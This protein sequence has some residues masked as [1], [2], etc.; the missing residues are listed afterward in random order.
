MWTWHAIQLHWIDH[1]MN[2]GFVGL[3]AYWKT[4]LIIIKA[5]TQ[6]YLMAHTQYCQYEHTIC[7]FIPY[8]GFTLVNILLY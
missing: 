5:S 4:L 1:F 3:K 6:T 7:E 8:S 2:L